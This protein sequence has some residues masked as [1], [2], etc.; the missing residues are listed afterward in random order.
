M[1]KV[2]ALVVA[3]AMGLSSV[4]FAAEAATTAPAATATTATAAP[5]KAQVKHHGKKAPV[6]K[7]QVVLT[8]KS[9]TVK[10]EAHRSGF[11]IQLDSD[12]LISG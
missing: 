6:Q 5:A 10:H 1:K 12:L 7:A 4:A 9:W 2:L 11:D 8:P 3:A